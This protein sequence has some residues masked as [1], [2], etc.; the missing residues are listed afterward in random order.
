M[1]LSIA[2]FIVYISSTFLF[3]DSRCCNI[4]LHPLKPIHATWLETCADRCRLDFINLR[5][6]ITVV[7]R[8]M[9]HN[10]NDPQEGHATW[11]QL[12]PWSTKPQRMKC[13]KVLNTIGCLCDD[14]ISDT[15]FEISLNGVQGSV[16]KHCQSALIC[17]HVYW[18]H[19]VKK[20]HR[21]PYH[22]HFC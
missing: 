12:C 17:Y 14:D 13:Q 3:C 20:E 16:R 9:C 7:Y 19:R 18:K 21:W 1:K 11:Q 5:L 8:I 4:S 6:H 10:V 2:N 22:R 15:E